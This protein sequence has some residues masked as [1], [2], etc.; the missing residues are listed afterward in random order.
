MNDSSGQPRV[1]VSDVVGFGAD[2]A[3][4]ARQALESDAPLELADDGP[5]RRVR[6]PGPPE[7]VSFPVAPMLDMAFQLLAFFI[8]TFQPASNELRI[9]LEMPVAAATQPRAEGGQARLDASRIGLADL[10]IESDLRVTAQSDAEGNLVSI[11][12]GLTQVPDVS[13]LEDRLKRYAKVLDNKPLSVTL[14]ADPRLLYDEAA[15]I[16]A[17]AQSAGARSIHLAEP[18]PS[19]SP[20]P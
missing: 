14:I 17:A 8:L 7:E 13:T 20:A 16:V 9:D 10:G 1:V 2:W 19:G 15:R 11:K 18:S 6:R 4:A 5:R 3:S 12:L